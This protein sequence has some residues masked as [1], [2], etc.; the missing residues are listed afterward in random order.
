ME[1]L[2]AFLEL[3]VLSVLWPEAG[4]YRLRCFGGGRELDLSGTGA[5]AAAHAVFEA[6]L[7]AP[8]EPLPLLTGAGRLLAKLGAGGA[9]EVTRE[10]RVVFAGRARTVARGQLAWPP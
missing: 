6:G 1:G 8:G 10:G 4:G 7:L 2:A 9:V 5:V 3:P